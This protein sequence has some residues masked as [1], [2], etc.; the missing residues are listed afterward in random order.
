MRGLGAGLW[1]A[2]VRWAAGGLEYS[3]EESF[4]VPAAM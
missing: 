4:E 2:R 3:M 1:R